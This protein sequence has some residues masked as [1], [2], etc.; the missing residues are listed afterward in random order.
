MT[1]KEAHTGPPNKWSAGAVLGGL[2]TAILVAA[3]YAIAYWN[4]AAWTLPAGA[5]LTSCGRAAWI[6]AYWHKGSLSPK[7]IRFGAAPVGVGLALAVLAWVGIP[8]SHQLPGIGASIYAVSMVLWLIVTEQEARRRRVELDLPPLA[9]TRWRI[10]LDESLDQLGKLLGRPN[11][12]ER[13]LTPAELPEL[14]YLQL[15]ALLFAGLFAAG[16]FGFDDPVREWLP[17]GESTTADPTPSPRPGESGDDSTEPT[18]DGGPTSPS[19]SPRPSPTPLYEQDQIVEDGPMTPD[20]C[21]Y[22][23]QR[24]RFL[25]GIRNDVGDAMFDALE[26]VGVAFIGCLELPVERVGHIWIARLSGWGAESGLVVSDKKGRA[27]VVFWH[28]RDRVEALVEDG[29][30][31]YAGERVKLA[32]GDYQIVFLDGGSCRIAI[33][34]AF[35][36]DI[37]YVFPPTAPSTLLIE[38]SIR[39]DAFP[40]GVDE[41]PEGSSRVYT[42][43]FT[44]SGSHS[45]PSSRIVLERSGRAFVSSNP[46]LSSAEDSPCPDVR[47]FDELAAGL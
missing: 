22:P 47:R 1:D 46:E 13:I 11:L 16:M 21:M 4:L 37:P 33:R 40:T 39:N 8:L 19:E 6:V 42:V 23:N 29:E 7:Q 17:A 32:K 30:L 44:S 38:E 27:A 12:G 3:A 9:G 28:L 25:E 45:P 36:D 43:D 34:R 18:P 10:R 26:D 35:G 24:A 14:N 5:A 15:L 31:R 2:G 41:A 20:E